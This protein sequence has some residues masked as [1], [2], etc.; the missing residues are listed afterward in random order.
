MK[1]NLTATKTGG[2]ELKVKKRPSGKAR[3]EET[4]RERQRKKE[5]NQIIVWRCVLLF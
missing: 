2:V 5:G 1:K 3:Q 4:K